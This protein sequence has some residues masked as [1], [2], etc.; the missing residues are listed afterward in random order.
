MSYHVPEPADIVGG[1]VS[2]TTPKRLTV[3][4]TRFS[5]SDKGVKPGSKAGI[6]DIVE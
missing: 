6:L 1:R 5:T 2:A 3:A 4:S